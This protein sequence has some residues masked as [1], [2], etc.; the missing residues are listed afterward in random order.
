[1]KEQYKVFVESIKGDKSVVFLEGNKL[2][3]QDEHEIQ[4]DDVIIEFPPKIKIRKIKQL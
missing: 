1:M 2:Y 4:I 3:H